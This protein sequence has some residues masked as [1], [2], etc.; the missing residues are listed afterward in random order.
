MGWSIGDVTSAISRGA[1]SVAQGM[2]NDM[3]A[4]GHEAAG[5]AQHL[6]GQAIS[7]GGKMLNRLPGGMHLGTKLVGQRGLQGNSGL[8]GISMAGTS[9][10]GSPAPQTADFPI[11]TVPGGGGVQCGTTDSWGGG[12]PFT[13]MGFVPIAAGAQTS[14][15]NIGDFHA[16]ASNPSI[17][18]TTGLIPGN[19]EVFEAYLSVGVRNNVTLSGI[20]SLAYFS[21]WWVIEQ[22]NG[23]E[24]ARWSFR[25]LGLSMSIQ[26]ML[27]SGNSASEITFATAPIEWHRQYDPNVK[28]NLVFQPS[29]TAT[30]ICPVDFTFTEIGVRP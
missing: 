18:T 12:Q 3:T 24:K 2:A 13:L 10:T 16:A 21:S 22:V 19:I 27:T 11:L 5:V 6:V 26:G 28:S 17:I 23:I 29:V 14:A 8:A 20:E 25:Q 15:T 30:T 7:Q 1:T 4:A 9:V